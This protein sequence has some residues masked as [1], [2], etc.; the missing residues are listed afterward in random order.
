MGII[1][2]QLKKHTGHYIQQ[3]LLATGIILMIIFSLEVDTHTVIIASL[4]ASTF[5]AFGMPHSYASAPRR[6]Y[7]GYAVGVF[8]GLASYYLKL[9]LL[10]LDPEGF[11]GINVFLGALAI[12]ASI[13]IMVFTNTEHPPAAGLSIGLI[14]N[15]W[16]AQTIVVIVFAIIFLNTSK[17][18]LRN[19]LIDLHG[20][21]EWQLEE[22]QDNDDPEKNID[23]ENPT[24]HD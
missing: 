14:F 1:D 15:P 18:F 22:C 23:Q 6:I 4:G 13:F 8:V 3:C 7:G 11:E 19:W 21:K 5:I 17:Y 2:E 10:Y 9:F 16:N 20:I 12:G 24:G